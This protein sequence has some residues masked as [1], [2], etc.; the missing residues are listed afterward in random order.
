M[1]AG[2]NQEEAALRTQRR[3][4]SGSDAADLGIGLERASGS[5]G[6]S[7]S[8]AGR[9]AGIAGSA[10]AASAGVAGSAAAGRAGGAGGSAGEA[11]GVTDAAKALLA[12]GRAGADDAGSG[13]VAACG[14]AEHGSVALLFRGRG[15]VERF[16]LQVVEIEYE[17][18]Q[19][20]PPR[21][22]LTNQNWDSAT[23]LKRSFKF[24]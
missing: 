7:E 4:G 20:L 14:E 9:A 18:L 10:A 15:G 19:D 23:H 5:A 2:R 6:Q 11:A 16:D 22:D 1:S 24:R 12:F 8:A 21:F 17:L 13:G 3:W